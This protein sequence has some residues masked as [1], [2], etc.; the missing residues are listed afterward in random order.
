MH[1]LHVLQQ[2]NTYEMKIKNT[3][4]EK[5]LLHF[6]IDMARK[7][8]LLVRNYGYDR[9]SYLIRNVINYIDQHLSG[10]LTLA[11]LARE[12][13]KNPS[14]LSGAFKKETG[15]PSPATSVSSGFRHPC[16]ILIPQILVSPR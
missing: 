10:E 11:I 9:Y 8:A 16:V 4:S 3:D 14:Y 13:G 5:E 6:P 1:P 15:T 2:W 12:F 7:Y